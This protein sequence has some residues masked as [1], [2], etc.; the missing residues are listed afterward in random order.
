MNIEKKMNEK[1]NSNPKDKNNG[2]I[3]IGEGVPRNI[4]KMSLVP[5]RSKSPLMGESIGGKK[6]LLSK[7]KGVD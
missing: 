4:N 1:R 5:I 3:K 2:S 6:D 7:L